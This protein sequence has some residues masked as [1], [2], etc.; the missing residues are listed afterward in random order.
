[1]KKSEVNSFITTNEVTSDSNFSLGKTSELDSEKID[2]SCLKKV[3]ELP[4]DLEDEEYQR[5]AAYLSAHPE[6]W[7]TNYFDLL[8]RAEPRSPKRR[9]VS[10]IKPQSNDT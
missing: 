2:L 1:M 9:R 5:L 7:K 6:I 3:S 10:K 4:D 8:N